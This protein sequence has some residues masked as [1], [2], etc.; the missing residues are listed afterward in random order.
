MKHKKIMQKLALIAGTASLALMAFICPM[1]VMP[2]QA[3][4]LGTATVQPRQHDIEYRYKIENGKLYKRLYDYS[5]GEWLGE[6]IYVCDYP[7]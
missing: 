3:A 5:T 7:G 1:S 6:W 4:S 2:T